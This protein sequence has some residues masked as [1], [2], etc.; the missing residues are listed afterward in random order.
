MSQSGHV[1]LRNV[2]GGRARPF[3][4]VRVAV[5]RAMCD[6]CF[7]TAM[8]LLLI[9][10]AARGDD[11][12]DYW[13]TVDAKFAHVNYAA[14]WLWPDLL[15]VAGVCLV[16]VKAVSGHSEALRQ[17]LR[18]LKVC[19]LARLGILLRVVSPYWRRRRAEPTRREALIPRG[20]RMLRG[21]CGP[22]GA[23]E[24]SR[25]RTRYRVTKAPTI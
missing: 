17:G 22:R 3:G 7:R 8:L 2:D 4:R 15:A 19:K 5:C 10:H 21:A 12:R 20:A 24:S 14:G 6:G 11:V 23:A 18:I 13:Q 9:I 16:P 25:P 1:S